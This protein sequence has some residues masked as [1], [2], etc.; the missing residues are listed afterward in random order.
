MFSQLYLVVCINIVS[1]IALCSYNSLHSLGRFGG[2]FYNTGIR[3][4]D[5]I[6][7]CTRPGLRIWQS[8]VQGNVQQTLLFKVY[9]KITDKVIFAFLHA[10]DNITK[11][12]SQKTRCRKRA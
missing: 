7:Y 11:C 2:I 10:K 6:L 12:T 4:N 3:P 9:D 5:V 8:D 1:Y